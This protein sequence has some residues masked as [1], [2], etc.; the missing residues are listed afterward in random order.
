MDIYKASVKC[1]GKGVIVQ[2]WPLMGAIVAQLADRRPHDWQLPL[3]GAVAVGGDGAAALPAVAAIAC[4]QIAIILLDDMLDEDQRGYHHQLGMAQAANLASA[5]Q[6]TAL[7]LVA[8]CP[9][10][11][12]VR[13]Q[14]MARLNQMMAMTALG[15]AW[16]C[17]NP[18]GEADYWQL[19]R[20]KSSPFFGAALAVGALLGGADLLLAEQLGQFGQLY[21]EMIQIHDDLHDSMAVPAAADWLQGRSSLP[22]LYAQLVNHPG[23][24]R[25]LTLRQQII[26]HPRSLHEAQQILL[27]CGAISYCL[28]QLLNRLDQAHTLLNQLPLSRPQPLQQLLAQLTRPVQALLPSTLTGFIPWQ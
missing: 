27:Q 28:H 8:D 24:E 14:V 6:A 15:Q 1:I 10:S 3:W 19:I 18:T 23:R 16:D 20:T 5:F 13:L 2:N 26:D 21:G 4:C 7:D 11:R 25:F 22:I 9:A 17:Q 12:P